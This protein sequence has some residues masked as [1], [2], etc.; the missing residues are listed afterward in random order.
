MVETQLVRRGVLD[1]R[2]LQ[3]FREV[4][5][6]EFVPEHLSGAAFDDSPASGARS[7]TKPSMTSAQVSPPPSPWA[8][9]P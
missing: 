7:D 1:P 4:A 6:E 2:V 5:R 9:S 8:F 3:A